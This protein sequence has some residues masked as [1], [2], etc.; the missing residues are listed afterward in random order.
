MEVGTP[1]PCITPT[2]CFVR[3][4]HQCFDSCMSRAKGFCPLRSSHSCTEEYPVLLCCLWNENT[5]L[6]SPHA[7]VHRASVSSTCMWLLF[8]GLALLC[9]ALACPAPG[10]QAHPW[11]PHPQSLR[12]QAVCGV[13]GAGRGHCGVARGRGD[14]LP[15]QL[16]AVGGGRRHF[17]HPAV[18]VP[19]PSACYACLCACVCAGSRFQ[20]RVSSYCVCSFTCLL[21][22]RQRCVIGVRLETSIHIAASMPP[23]PTHSW[24]CGL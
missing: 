12:G 21:T 19:E 23:P 16:H 14:L 7:F 1:P 24:M 22:H 20:Q 18:Q 6:S 8:P 11:P 5:L 9:H 17:L 10:L 13:R 4:G 2:L 15:S 3:L